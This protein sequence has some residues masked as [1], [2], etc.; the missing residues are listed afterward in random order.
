M[1]DYLFEIYS[2]EI[3]ARFQ[4]DGA[5]QLSQ[6]FHE[7]LMAAHLTYQKIDTYVTPRR[8][9]ANIQGLIERQPDYSEERRGPRVGAPQ[10]AID[11]FA[12]SVGQ[13]IDGLERRASDKG[14]FYFATFSHVGQETRA[15]LPDLVVE[16]LENFSWPK[17]MRW[18]T[19][20]KSWV[21]PIHRG[22]SIFNGE[23]LPITWDIGGGMHIQFG[24]DT[25]G[26]YLI[27]PA[28]LK[29]TGFAD[30]QKALADHHVLL[31][32]D[33]RKDAIVKQVDALAA[34]ENLTVGHEENLLTEVAGL[35]ECP[36]SYLGTID[37]AFMHLP[38]ELLVTVMH[39]HQRYF[40][41]YDGNGKLA[42]KF[43]V[44]ANRMTAD[45]GATIVDGN[46]RVLRA[47]FND[48]RFF[49][50]NDRKVSL[51]EH[52]KRLSDIV[53]HAQLGTVQDKVDRLVKLAAILAPRVDGNAPVLEEAARLCKA[54]L[55]TE[56]VYE[57]PELQGVMGRYYA[58]DSA[59]EVGAAIGEHYLPAGSGD[60]IPQTAAGKV[61]AVIDRV[62]TLVGFFGIG[63][64]P[65]GSKD[66]FALRRACLGILRILEEGNLPIS[67]GE[68]L[69]AA[70]AVYGDVLT[71]AAEE[72]KS[73]LVNF[74]LERLSVFW[75][76][77]GL[78]YD[79]IRA[80]RRFLVN[81]PLPQVR[82]NAA[83]IQVFCSSSEGE[84]LLQ[85][86]TRAYSILEKEQSK[87]GVRYDQ[88][89]DADLLSD[90]AEK[91]LLASLGEL[92]FSDDMKHSLKTLAEL[93]HPIDGFF[94][95]VVVNSDDHRVRQNRLR[96]L[97][98]VV[99]SM[100]KLADFEEI[101]VA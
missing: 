28:P 1:A 7:K 97:H 79:V 33:A 3:P 11:G 98:K 43:A 20:E 95:T 13:S 86:F 48:A 30:Y 88:D 77:S 21:R 14:E 68:V 99:S 52:G 92:V 62:D 6:L 51:E 74:C 83:A 50:D 64:Q 93:R 53:F 78:R 59:P 55:V 80:V 71:V 40:P 4:E 91:K 89:V 15:L 17:S 85:G 41:L 84:N 56:M 63:I 96:L 32:M 25:R 12:R 27:D 67:L 35:V 18:G 42:S 38:P 23:V 46:E 8:L 49:Y 61:L 39:H 9:V 24:G 75:K 69:D 34:K 70:I 101:Q 100:Q 31:D 82:Q 47:R 66:P 44:V 29:V 57:F 58:A 65:T 87:D 5:N 2:E 81:S 45:K 54:D 16:I 60:N 26:H 90:I 36:V 73:Q 37:D 94:T 22:V 76:D 72:L 19:S 10:G